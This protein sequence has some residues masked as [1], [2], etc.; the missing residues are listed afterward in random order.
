MM[1]GSGEVRFVLSVLFFFFCC[2]NNRQH[3]NAFPASLFLL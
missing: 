2:A 3:T 1:E